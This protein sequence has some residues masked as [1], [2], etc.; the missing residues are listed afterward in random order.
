MIP[1]VRLTV[2][3]ETICCSTE[4]KAGTALKEACGQQTP[5]PLDLERSEVL[6]VNT[7]YDGR[8]RLATDT[9]N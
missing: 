4:T 3:L 6:E 5:P 7:V 8:S 1:E 9:H 2:V